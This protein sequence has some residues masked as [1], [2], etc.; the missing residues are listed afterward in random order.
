MK[1]VYLGADHAG[2]KAKEAIQKFLARKGIRTVDFGA[3]SEESVDYPDYAI[4]VAKAVV[5]DK[6]SLG[7]LICGTGIGMSIAAN[8]IKKIRAAH[9]T[10]TKEARMAKEHNDANVLCFG[11]RINS[12]SEIKKMI[13]AF[14]KEKPSK[15]KRHMKRV[16]KLDRL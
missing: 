6:G 11:S 15:V 7:V 4:K 16:A 2:Y 5:K 10:S 9:V 13:N 14:L 3:H 12:D 1:K 8:K